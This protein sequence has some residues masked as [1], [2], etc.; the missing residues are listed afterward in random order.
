MGRK[1]QL[2]DRNE[3]TAEAG[4]MLGKRTLDYGT[5]KTRKARMHIMEKQATEK[6]K[7]HLAQSM[8]RLQGHI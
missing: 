2:R 6:R 7:A 3:G 1:T 5:S 4:N 8:D